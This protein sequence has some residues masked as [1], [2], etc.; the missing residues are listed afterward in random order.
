MQT[1]FVYSNQVTSDSIPVMFFVCN[2]VYWRWDGM[3][4]MNVWNS[5]LL[6]FLILGDYSM[7]VSGLVMDLTAAQFIVFVIIV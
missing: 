4:T 6:Q 5:V 2:T 7:R 3:E 1:A